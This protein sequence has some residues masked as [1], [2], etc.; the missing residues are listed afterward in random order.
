MDYHISM[1]SK[2]LKKKNSSKPTL[3]SL[4]EGLNDERV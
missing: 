2:Y 3:A 1:I 4:T